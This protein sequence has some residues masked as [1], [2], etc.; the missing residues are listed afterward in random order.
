MV[1]ERYNLLPDWPVFDICP[2]K[3]ACRLLLAKQILQNYGGARKYQRL[4]QQLGKT[5]P[6]DVM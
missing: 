4:Q 1:K 5:P 2:Q 6:M 3:L